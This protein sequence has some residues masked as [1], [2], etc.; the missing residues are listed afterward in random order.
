MYLFPSITGESIRR[1]RRT[2][3]RPR[4][5]RRW[6]CVM[7]DVY[8]VMRLRR[9]DW[10]WGC[11]EH[12]EGGW[13]GWKR[14]CGWAV[15]GREE[16]EGVEWVEEGDGEDCRGESK[17]AYWRDGE[18]L[19]DRL[20]EGERPVRTVFELCCNDKGGRVGRTCLCTR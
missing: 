1:D 3:R 4:Y 7:R 5:R 15:C 11:G 9:G 17:E 19:V 16:D 2:I 10:R 18:V 12:G 8:C 6:L 20:C 13:A 14:A